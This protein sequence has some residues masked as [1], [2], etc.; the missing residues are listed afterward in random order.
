MLLG[1]LEAKKYDDD[2]NAI[3]GHDVDERHDD[4]D[5]MMIDFLNRPIYFLLPERKLVWNS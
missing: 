1:T 5:D 3:G 4:D 2:A